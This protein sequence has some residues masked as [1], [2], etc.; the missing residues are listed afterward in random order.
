[1][2]WRFWSGHRTYFQKQITNQKREGTIKGPIGL[3][4]NRKHHKGLKNSIANLETLIF[5]KWENI[6]TSE[7]SCIH[8]TMELLEV[9]QNF[10]VIFWS[11]FYIFNRV[12][13]KLHV[14]STK[15]IF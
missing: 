12:M 9:Y 15:F 10:L 2:C 8:M 4:Y 11:F 5:H 1:M 6:K 3:N 14:I 13:N 7:N